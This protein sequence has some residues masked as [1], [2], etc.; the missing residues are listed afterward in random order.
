M[1]KKTTPEPVLLEG[2]ETLPGFTAQEVPPAQPAP[3]VNETQPAP[4]EFIGRSKIGI[5]A[6][7]LDEITLKSILSLA[8]TF[9]GLLDQLEERLEALPE[10]KKNLAP[11]L[12][13]E[14]PEDS[15]FLDSYDLADLL[16][17]AVDDDGN[18]K[19]G[20]LK[21]VVER[22]KR[23][24]TESRGMLQGYIRQGPITNQLTKMIATTRNTKTDNLANTMTIRRGTYTLSFDGYENLQGP[25]VST[26][27]L[28]DALTGELTRTGAKDPEVRLPLKEYMRLRG[29]SDVKATREQVKEDL[30]TLFRGRLSAKSDTGKGWDQDF[31]DIRICQGKGLRKGVIIFKY[32]Y[33]LFNFL[34]TYNV[35][36]MQEQ[37]LG[38]NGKK[39]PNSYFLLR[40]I[41]EHKNMNVGKK[42]ED[43]ISVKTL[44]ESCPGLPSYEE[45]RAGRL[46]YDRK[47]KG[48][49]ERDLDALANTL[50]WEYCHRNGTPLTDTELAKFD[51][52]IFIECLIHVI[53]NNYPDQT[54]RLEKQAARREEAKAAAKKKSSRK[55]APKKKAGGSQTDTT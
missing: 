8:K 32:G 22:A 25:R 28:F 41:M 3:E 9:Q 49:F 46:G 31:Y 23:R 34:K 29:L 5:P 39:N 53:W 26:Y 21:E 35:M 50:R 36:P 33:D 52:A 47:I 14:L 38:L 44:L 13:A 11:F 43:L 6:D 42:N 18:A 30:E 16:A 1:D 27:Q 40:R 10:P 24:Q 2:Q 12:L 51:Y 37:L 7:R 55:A 48:P 15:E 20:P 19:D 45:V 17:L 54:K 4:D